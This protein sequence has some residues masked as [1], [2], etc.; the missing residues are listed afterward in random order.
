MKLSLILIT[1][2]VVGGTTLCDLCGPPL[3]SA[4]SDLAA[5]S[6]ASV[7]AV[8]AVPATDTVTLRIEGM[9]CAG[10]TIA[11]RAVL[12]RLDGVVK[13]DV[14]YETKTAIV[15]YDPAKVTTD[16]MIAAVAT[17]KYTATVVR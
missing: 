5:L 11:T 9:T 4:M 8:E 1:A 2:G 13:A 3:S 7:S 6:T 12:Q 15:I 14:S 17:L 10:C 16:Q